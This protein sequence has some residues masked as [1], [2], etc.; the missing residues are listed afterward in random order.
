MAYPNVLD[1]RNPKGLTTEEIPTRQLEE[2]S[3]KA[4]EAKR[5]RLEENKAAGEGTFCTRHDDEVDALL[6]TN[7]GTLRGQSEIP[8]EARR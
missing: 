6:G 2:Y 4:K 5:R 3:R 7:T 8:N 1:V